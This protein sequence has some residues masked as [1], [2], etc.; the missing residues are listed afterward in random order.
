VPSVAERFPH[1]LDDPTA[2]P[3]LRDVTVRVTASHKLDGAIS[4]LLLG[5]ELLHSC[6]LAP[7]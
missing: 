1:L 2:R 6:A 7:V 5:F 3:L 4:A